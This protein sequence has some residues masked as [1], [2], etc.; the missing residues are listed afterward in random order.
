[1]S[2]P[3]RGQALSA[4]TMVETGHGRLML[5]LRADESEIL[6]QPPYSSRGDR[7]SAEQL[8]RP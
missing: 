5:V 6:V 4:G 3:K 8:E 1:M 7:A 2:V